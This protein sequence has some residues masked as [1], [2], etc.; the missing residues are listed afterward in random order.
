MR[1]LDRLQPVGLLAMRFVLG[2]IMIVHGFPKVFGGMHGE[3]S[4]IVKLGLPWWSAYLSA[5]AEFLGGIL[6]LGG[7]LTRP[8]V[9]ALFIDMVV[10]IA[11]VH[12]KHGLTFEGDYQLPMAL[13]ALSF[14]LIFSG[15]GAISLDRLIFGRRGSGFQSQQRSVR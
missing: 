13:A 4:F 11:M 8:V 15:A 3:I 10:A 1:F 9:L 6:A 14:G 7:L 5:Y 2:V 12:W